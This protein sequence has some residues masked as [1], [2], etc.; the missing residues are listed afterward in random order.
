MLTDAQRFAKEA[1][2]ARKSGGDINQT[3]RQTGDEYADMMP[4]QEPEAKTPEQIA[5]DEG[6]QKTIQA[7]LDRENS[8]NGKKEVYEALKSA[9]KQQ[10]DIQK[11]I[12]RAETR[13]RETGKG[14]PTRIQQLKAKL[15][16]QNKLV[17]QI[18]SQLLYFD[19]EYAHNLTDAISQQEEIYSAARIRAAQAISD[20]E[21][22]KIT[23]AQKNAEVDAYNKAG[24]ELK[25]LKNMTHEQYRAELAGVGLVADLNDKPQKQVAEDR[26]AAMPGKVSQE[27]VDTTSTLG[28]DNINTSQGGAIDYGTGAENVIGGNGR[29]TEVNP[30]VLSFQGTA[31]SGGNV[32]P[33]DP[34]RIP[35]GYGEG[36]IHTSDSEGRELAPEISERQGTGAADAATVGMV[37]QPSGD[38]EKSRTVTNTG[39]RSADSDIRQSYR[40]GLNQDETLGDYR[41]RNQ[42]K[43][44]DEMIDGWIEEGF[45]KQQA[46][47]LYWLL[48]AA[49][50]K[51]KIDVVAWYNGK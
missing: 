28:Y 42:Y 14:S 30:G 3:L 38:V 23:N 50:G 39:L 48:G 25:R 17:S 18:E 4:V 45:T 22:G 27:A 34:G 49:S 6:V 46:N 24:A 35:G 10:K 8:R 7:N 9:K 29:N 44:R 15:E 31:N 37:N 1:E 43:T 5:L 16:Q 11:E 13:L 2:E 26:T 33:G 19:G 40:D 36:T 51:R 12:D 32:R 21:A 47:E 41:V 20:Y